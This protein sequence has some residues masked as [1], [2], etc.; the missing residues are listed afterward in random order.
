[1]SHQPRA[2]QLLLQAR[3]RLLPQLMLQVVVEILP[4]ILAGGAV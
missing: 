1:M 4:Q 2:V 3:L